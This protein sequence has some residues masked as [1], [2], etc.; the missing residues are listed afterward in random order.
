VD[1]AYGGE[2]QERERSKDA[3]RADVE[4]RRAWISVRP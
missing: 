3:D 2:A 4:A 1:V